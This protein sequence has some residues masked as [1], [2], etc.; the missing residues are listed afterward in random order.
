MQQFPC[1]FLQND[2]V[3]KCNLQTTTTQYYLHYFYINI[4][5]K[6]T[7]IYI[8]YIDILLFT[9]LLWINAHNNLNDIE[10]H[11]FLYTYVKSIY[12]YILQ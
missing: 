11:T 5:I 8:S 3:I 9:L 10:Y 4:K 7:Y 1:S 6:H 12:A 2:A